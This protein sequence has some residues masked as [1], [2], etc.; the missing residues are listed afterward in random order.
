MFSVFEENGV[1]DM[2]TGMEYRRV[3]LEKGGTKE[4][5]DLVQEFLGRESNNK[6]F[7]KSM[8]L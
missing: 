7:L 1:M 2:K 6:A 3:I 8:G 4:A 5:L